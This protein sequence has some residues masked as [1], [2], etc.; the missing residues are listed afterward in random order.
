MLTFMLWACTTKPVEMEKN[1]EELLEEYYNELCL[2]YVD[3]DCALEISQCGQP[4]TLFSDW[5]QCMNAQSNRTTL[6]GQLPAVIENEPQNLV[7][8]ISLLQSSACTS[9]DI[10]P[11]EELESFDPSLNG[12]GAKVGFLKKAPK[13]FS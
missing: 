13:K 9:D 12:K 3:E 2:L 4:V 6:C 11:D 8:C 1:G 7:D 5:A 10:C